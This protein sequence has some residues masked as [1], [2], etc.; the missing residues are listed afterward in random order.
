MLLEFVIVK[1]ITEFQCSDPTLKVWGFQRRTFSI[2]DGFIKWQ[3]KSVV[4]FY[5]GERIRDTSSTQIEGI[6]GELFKST[7][8]TLFGWESRKTFKVKGLS[9]TS[10]TEWEKGEKIS[11]RFC[12]SVKTCLTSSKDKCN[13]GEG[14]TL[15]N[16]P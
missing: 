2:S 6:H 16:N 13:P 12:G 8:S 15:L 4:N 1:K 10:G 11:G 5:P 14:I 9:T 7:R 3:I